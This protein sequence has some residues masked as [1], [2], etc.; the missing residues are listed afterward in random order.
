MFDEFFK[1]ITYEEFQGL[2]DSNEPLPLLPPVSIKGLRLKGQI[3]VVH[4]DDGDQTTCTICYKTKQ[5]IKPMSKLNGREVM[6]CTPVNALWV[7]DERA[8][9]LSYVK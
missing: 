7:S 3:K 5:Y 2:G 1:D 8:G 6:E 9:Y 4:T